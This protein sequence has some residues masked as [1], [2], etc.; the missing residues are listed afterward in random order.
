MNVYIIYTY[1]LHNDGPQNPKTPYFE[2]YSIVK[3]LFL[4]Y[5]DLKSLNFVNKRG[6]EGPLIGTSPLVEN[7]EGKTLIISRLSKNL[8]NDTKAFKF[9]IRIGKFTKREI[10]KTG[11]FKR[12]V[13]LNKGKALYFNKDDIKPAKD[14]VLDYF[15]KSKK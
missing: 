8:D 12:D 7:Y 4:R 5:Y 1:Y 6:G 15:K 9:L 2:K 13:T 11:R 10:D 3:I 14:M